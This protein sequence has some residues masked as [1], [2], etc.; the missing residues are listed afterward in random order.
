MK[1]I[2]LSV[3]FIFLFYSLCYSQFQR[4][5]I[6]MGEYTVSGISSIPSFCIDEALDAPEY[7]HTFINSTP[8]ISVTKHI[9]STIITKP[10]SEV[11]GKWIKITGND[12]SINSLNV[13][14]VNPKDK[15]TY[16]LKVKNTSGFLSGKGQSV[17][18]RIPNEELIRQY[19]KTLN[20]YPDKVLSTD[21]LQSIIWSISGTG[22]DVVSKKI[23]Y[24]FNKYNTNYDK[25]KSSLGIDDEFTKNY[26]RLFSLYI[27]GK[28]SN[29]EIDLLGEHLLPFAPEGNKISSDLI[30]IYSGKKYTNHELEVL[31]EVTGKILDNNLHDLKNA[32]L[33]KDGYLDV[34]INTVNTS[35]MLDA[36]DLKSYNFSDLKGKDV[37][38][39]NM[40]GRH[41]SAD[42][43]S[44]LS[45][46]GIKFVNNFS[47]I[48]KQG[49]IKGNIKP[50]FVS[51]KNPNVVKKLFSTEKD[52]NEIINITSEAEKIKNAVL[53]ETEE[54]LL[55][56]LNNASK[57]EI[58]IVIFDNG[59]NGI[60]FDK[61]Y[62]PNKLPN[63]ISCKSYEY[64]DLPY[65]T[66]DYMDY[67]C[68]VKALAKTQLSVEGAT[69]V[70]SFMK[71]YAEYYMA[72]IGSKK[73]TFKAGIIIGAIAI[74]GGTFYVYQETKNK[75]E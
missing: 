10:L 2:S 28:R 3:I 25:L 55:K 20:S 64:N 61:P 12:F 23:M 68:V 32:I 66:T 70:S 5:R 6:P 53:V 33:I 56:S 7:Y 38:I 45:E 42:L 57:T 39:S 19:E 9:G 52:V 29:A 13:S 41:I 14:P 36:S 21:V 74:G 46:A 75:K 71:K 43:A 26:S 1:K 27:D 48:L 54:E 24:G 30:S 15:A 50:I 47:N 34:K 17:N 31:S 72:C 8:N 60:M 65:Q 73:N 18:K 58:P 69:H 67:E 44:S 62:N 49:E 22:T 4:M 63:A 16:T 51:S 40:Y 35:K 11:N 37:Y 59:K